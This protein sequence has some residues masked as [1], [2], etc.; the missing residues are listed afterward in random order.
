MKRYIRS[1]KISDELISNPSLNDDKIVVTWIGDE[2]T[3]IP[4][5]I[6]WK[7]FGNN[8]HPTYCTYA[9][10]QVGDEE[11]PVAYQD[12]KKGRKQTIF[13]YSEPIWDFIRDERTPKQQAFIDSHLKEISDACLKKDGRKS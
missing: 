9:Y 13:I 12:Y 4:R 10:I 11:F 5:D 3:E 6:I 1:T 7:Y 2:H 8:V